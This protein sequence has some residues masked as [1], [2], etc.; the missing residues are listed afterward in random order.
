M[1][2]TAYIEAGSHLDSLYPFE[3]FSFPEEIVPL[4]ASSG[5]ESGFLYHFHLPHLWDRFLSG[6]KMANVFPP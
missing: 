2:S 5:T 6:T 4:K 3:D 1:M